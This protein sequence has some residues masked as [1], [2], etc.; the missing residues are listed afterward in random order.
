MTGNLIDTMVPVEI[1][2]V[3]DRE[4]NLVALEAVL[5]NQSYELVKVTSG[6]AALR[7]L[8]DHSPA[9][10][11]LDVQMPGLDGFAT[12]SIIKGSER[13]REIPI[14]FLT[15]INKDDHYRARGYEHG[16]VDYLYKPFD[17]QVL[18][19]KVSVFAELYRK[20][21]KLLQAERR[22]SEAARREQSRKFAE[23]EVKSLR[24]AQVEQRRYRELVDGINHGMVWSADTRHF[25]IS[26]MSP[27]AESILGFPSSEWFSEARLWEKNLH[28]ADRVLFAQA[29]SGLVLDGEP[30]TIEHRFVR[31][32]K[33]IVWLQTG[34]RLSSVDEHQEIR[35]LSVDITKLKDA[36][37]A[38]AQAKN[39]SDLLAEV[40]LLLTQTL[41]AQCALNLVATALTENFCTFVSIQGIDHAGLPRTM[42]VAHREASAVATL[43]NNLTPGESPA[44]L[45]IAEGFYQGCSEADVLKLCA[46][47]EQL[48]PLLNLRLNS[49]IVR[50]LI[51]RGQRIGTLVLG[52]A[53]ED[54]FTPADAS[55]AEDICFRIASAMDNAALYRD[56]QKA[57]RMRDEFLSI[58]SHELKTPLT[59]LKIQT[60]Q[61]LR[62]IAKDSLS[63]VD[64]A[65]V[66]R[67]LEISNRQIERLN[68]LIEDLLD[69]SRISTGKMGLRI[70]EFDIMELLNDMAQRF[71]GHLASAGCELNLSGPPSLKVH[72]DSFRIEQILV[73]LLTNA[74]KY[75]PNKPVDCLVTA[76]REGVHIS[77][78]DQGMGI[79]HEDQDRIFGRFERAVSGT[80]FG[81]L[82]LGLYIST[83][84][85]EA[86]AGRLWVESELGAGSI[87]HLELPFESPGELVDPL[88]NPKLDSFIAN[89]AFKTQA[90][91]EFA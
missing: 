74:T 9:V 80:H 16:A 89:P 78:R 59:P 6:E 21:E 48:P 69:I 24:R 91:A 70:E 37:H 81:G 52:C 7:Y 12:A 34:L 88:H 4:E 17:A 2:L 39:R 53:G 36:E 29:L 31:A 44:N 86:H 66:N 20:T 42:A 35:G 61:L 27:R 49:A 11:L 87:F 30:I 58:A 50:P 73:N 22:L 75:A 56:A 1:L 32:D 90:A 38:Q 72:W 14:I 68:K 79:A 76:S 65:R 5:Q 46:F 26:Y 57:V 43:I 40:S 83:Q 18:R 33:K 63:S 47:P 67:M 15:A 77:V 60:Q 62:L 13:T 8:L 23:A 10:I 19:S 71:S 51:A 64:P 28:P 84:I 55:F 82:G 54:S 85:A 41:D 45:Q 3:D 25:Q